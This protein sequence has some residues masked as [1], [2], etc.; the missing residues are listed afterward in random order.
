M[1]KTGDQSNFSVNFEDT[2]KIAQ[3]LPINK[4]TWILLPYWIGY[5]QASK[6]FKDGFLASGVSREPQL[7]EKP[8][9]KSIGLMV[10][11]ISNFK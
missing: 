9:I 8:K 7:Q 5:H 3:K 4:V 10:L 2:F 1:Q 6:Y 11:Q